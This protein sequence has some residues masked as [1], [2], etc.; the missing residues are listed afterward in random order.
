[1]FITTYSS[2]EVLQV[3]YREPLGTGPSG[4]GLGGWFDDSGSAPDSVRT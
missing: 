2:P 3:I 4:K 1:M